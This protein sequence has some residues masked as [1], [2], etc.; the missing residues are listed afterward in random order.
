MIC[1]QCSSSDVRRSTTSTL[2]DSLARLR[3]QEAFRCRK[4]RHRFHAIPSTSFAPEGADASGRRIP[5]S[6]LSKRRR[7]KRLYRRVLTAV[8]IF[9]A[10]SLFGAFL[11]YISVDHPPQPTPQEMSL[12]DQ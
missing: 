1:P 6:E 7:R 8:V 11:H 3:G 5:V 10:V 2:K 9:A 4:C 12:P